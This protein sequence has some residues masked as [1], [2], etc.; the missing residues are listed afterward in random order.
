MAAK[1]RVIALW[2]REVENRVGALAGT[3]EPLATAGAD[4]EVLM[5][6][7]YPGEAG[8]AAIEV[9]PIA[10]KKA[11]LAA[12]AAGLEPTSIPALVVQGKNRAGRAHAAAAAIAKG[13]INLSFLMAQ[14]VDK[15]FSAVLGFAT[16]ADAK[17]AAGL[18]KKALASKKKK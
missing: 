14:V 7:T 2:R 3:L 18:V 1:V 6:Y 9:F 12:R 16:E 15:K 8:K 11:I 13:G 17:R 5:A 10:G 4:L